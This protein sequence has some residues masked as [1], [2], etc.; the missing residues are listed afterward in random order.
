MALSIKRINTTVR[1]TTLKHCVF[2]TCMH[3]GFTDV[4]H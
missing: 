4:L 3:F 1:S 2:E